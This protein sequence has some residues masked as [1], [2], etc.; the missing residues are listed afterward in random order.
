MTLITSL[1]SLH[2]CVPEK[3]WVCLHWSYAFCYLGMWFCKN[4]WVT[5]SALWCWW[6]I[7]KS[8]SSARSYW[9]VQSEALANDLQI[10]LF[11]RSSNKHE[12]NLA[13]SRI[14]YID[15][16]HYRMPANLMLPKI[17]QIHLPLQW[18]ELSRAEHFCSQ[19]CA[20]LQ[21]NSIMIRNVKK[22]HTLHPVVG[23]CLGVA[24]LAAFLHLQ[25][26]PD[27]KIMTGARR[28]WFL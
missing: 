28:S 24:S 14:F 19:G 23:S 22:H 20:T 3:Q 1:S 7:W 2:L 9:A 6:H 12:N 11:C 10:W 15:S 18:Q 16:P 8:F 13:Y 17:M 21:S 4:T 5:N 27:S 25:F 26:I